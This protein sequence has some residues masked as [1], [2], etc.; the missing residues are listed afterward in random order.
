MPNPIRVDGGGVDLSTRFFESHA[1]AGSPALAAET[2]ICTLTVTADVIVA[3]GIQLYG[4]AAFTVGTSGSAVAFK[5]RQ[6]GTSGAT[7]ASSGAT[8][9]GIS[10]GNLATLDVQGLDAAG[11]LP[12]QVYVLTM[13]VTA[14]AAVS[15]VSATQ[16]TALVV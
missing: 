15:T 8:T 12:G 5:I 4:W 13:Q 3:K 14:G 2:V 9:A 16:L 1:V 11:V 7:I 10:A 6:T